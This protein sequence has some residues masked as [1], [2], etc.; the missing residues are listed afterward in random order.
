MRNTLALV[1][2]SLI[3]LFGAASDNAQDRPDLPTWVQHVP[4]INDPLK[5][6]AVFDRSN[7][8]ILFCFDFDQKQ[9]YPDANGGLRDVPLTIRSYTALTDGNIGGLEVNI[10][11]DEDNPG[12]NPGVTIKKINKLEPVAVPIESLLSKKEYFFAIKITNAKSIKYDMRLT[13]I[14]KEPFEQIFKLRMGPPPGNWLSVDDDQ[15]TVSC[16][17]GDACSPVTLTLT[18]QIPYDITIKSITITS[19]PQDLLED[20]LSNFQPVTIGGNETYSLKLQAK[21]KP[22]SLSRIFSGFGKSPQL[23]AVLNLRDDSDRVGSSK[24]RKL[25]LQMRPNVVVLL[26]TVLLGVAIGTVIRIDLGRLEKAGLIS[27]KQRFIFAGTTVAT[28]LLVSLIALFTN[29]KMVVFD[30][31]PYSTWDPRMLFLTGLVGTI[32]GIPILYGLLK[33]PKPTQPGAP[34]DKPHTPSAP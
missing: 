24:P 22:M 25:N 31:Q 5:N 32:G 9:L 20:T 7:R 16:W 13:G 29:L 26:I 3:L 19:D 14:Y 2:F 1:I 17:T 23:T 4:C 12:I 27:R 21:A 34:D 6:R 11:T 8:E 28:G 33:L 10:V 18:N 15:A 30:D